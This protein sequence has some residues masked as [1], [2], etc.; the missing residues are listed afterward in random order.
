MG[1]NSNRSKTVSI[2]K[3]LS[4]VLRH[5]PEVIGMKLEPG[6]WLDVDQLIE[7]ASKVGKRFD[8]SLL[9]DVV[10]NND[11][12]RF[13]LSDDGQKI[14]ASQGHSVNDVELGLVIQQPP[15]ILYHGTVDKVLGSIRQTGLSKRSRN[16]V[17][18]SADIATA[19]DVG[20]R[21][22]QP[23]ILSVESGRMHRDGRS[24]FLSANHVWLTDAVPT[25]YLNF[26]E[27]Q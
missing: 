8:R 6:G 20:Q 3:F 23:V 17:H 19:Q 7:N 10:A 5:Q 26:P 2:S 9:L 16:H 22:G 21:R 15:E 12:Q 25:E 13:A 4:L 1:D 18:L 27:T 11:K 24:F 14:R